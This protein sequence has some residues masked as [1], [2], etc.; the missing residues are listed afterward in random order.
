MYK[1]FINTERFSSGGGTKNLTAHQLDGNRTNPNGWLGGGV[2]SR[3]ADED[4]NKYGIIILNNNGGTVYCS[5][6][7]VDQQWR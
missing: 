4:R 7:V 6:L 3:E 2:D 5:K 1:I